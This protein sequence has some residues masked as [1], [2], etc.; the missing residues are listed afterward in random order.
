MRNNKRLNFYNAIMAEDIDAIKLILDK[1]INVN[2]QNNNKRTILHLIALK[3]NTDIMNICKNYKYDPNI[4]DCHN[5]IALHFAV[6]NKNMDIVK[7]LVEI[8]SD[9]NAKDRYGNTPLH[10]ATYK[11]N[12]EVIKYLL[13]NGANPNFLNDASVT[14]LSIAK[15]Q[16]NQELI[17]LIT[18]FGGKSPKSY[19]QV[20]KLAFSSCNIF[21]KCAVILFTISIMA[22]TIIATIMTMGELYMSIIGALFA[23]IGFFMVCLNKPYMRVRNLEAR[24]FN[25]TVTKK[26][27]DLLLFGKKQKDNAVYKH[28]KL[29]SKEL[30]TQKADNDNNYRIKNKNSQEDS[31]L[32][33][34]V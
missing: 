28:L 6:Q 20:I 9:I 14:I 18:K 21:R 10:L 32:T 11:E 31:K 5:C 24:I 33:A 29:S 16:K 17:K 12:T 25:Q 1:D 7:Y 15:K 3:G 34:E 22:I 19:F 23:S 26:E 13:Q 30:H 8:N 4:R 2:R 27:A